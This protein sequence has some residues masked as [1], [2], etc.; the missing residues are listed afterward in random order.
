MTDFPYSND[1]KRYHTL[2]YHNQ[3]IFGG[4]V[5]KAAI[6]AGLTCPN[7]DGSKGTGGCL[8]CQDGAG[9]F[10]AA[11]AVPVGE[12]ARRELAR[13]REKHP[14]ARAIAYFQAHSNTYGPLERLAPLYEEALAVEGVCGLSIATRADVISR[15]MLDYLEALS[16]RTYLTVELGLQTIHDPTAAAINRCHSYEEFL[17]AYEA[18]RVRDIRTCVHIIDGLPGEDRAMMIETAAALGRLRP[19]AVKIH[20]LHVMEGTGLAAM[21]EAGQY[22]PLTFAEYVDTV[23]KQLEYL[24][25]ETVIER[26]TGDGDKSRLLAPAWSRDKIAVLGAIDKTQAERNS[27]QG[28]RT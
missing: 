23:V 7:I 13:I 6:D 22:E 2:A 9:Y 20:L 4:R 28:L 27:R 19:Q 24:P 21:Y 11:P 26:L 18:L 5:Y 14:G 17:A 25:P 3:R 16:L 15:D 12:Q 10:T 8:F 1:N